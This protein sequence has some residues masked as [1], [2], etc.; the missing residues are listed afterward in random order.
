M[1]AALVQH[2]QP[3]C[4]LRAALRQLAA[5]SLPKGYYT[6]KFDCS[7]RIVLKILAFLVVMRIIHI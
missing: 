3:L 4:S 6:W 5:R 2:L 7:A 1:C